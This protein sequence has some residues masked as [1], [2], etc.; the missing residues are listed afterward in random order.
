[1]IPRTVLSFSDLSKTLEYFRAALATPFSQAYL[2][3]SALLSSGILMY[4]PRFFGVFGAA[5]ATSLL[6]S[7]MAA[8]GRQWER[9]P[10][11][12]GSSLP[13][14][15][16]NAIP[17]SQLCNCTWHTTLTHSRRQILVG[18]IF[19]PWPYREYSEN[20]PLAKIS[21]PTVRTYIQTSAISCQGQ[22]LLDSPECE[23][24]VVE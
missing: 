14:Q 13:L 5:S 8:D 7:S 19:T 4:D 2:P 18:V 12:L 1:M 20:F 16:Y 17:S 6:A 23:E 11:G 3:I 9:G 21:R 15:R 10:S 24:H 22:H